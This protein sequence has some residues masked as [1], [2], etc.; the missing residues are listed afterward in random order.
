MDISHVIAAN[1]WDID[2]IY[3]IN[4]LD[5]PKISDHFPKIPEDLQTSVRRC[6]ECFRA[7]SERFPAQ[8]SSVQHV[9]SDISI[10]CRRFLDAQI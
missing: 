2:L 7:F 4:L 9:R 10:H 6:Y 3:Y 5:F 1:Q 8:S